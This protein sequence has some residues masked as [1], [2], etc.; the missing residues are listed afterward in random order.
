MES[1]FDFDGII[2]IIKVFVEPSVTKPVLA[3]EIFTA[4]I[5][6]SSVS[7]H[8]FQFALVLMRSL[9]MFFDFLATEASNK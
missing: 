4:G 8:A 5:F 1:Y 6:W 2:I 3:K 7:L 9:I